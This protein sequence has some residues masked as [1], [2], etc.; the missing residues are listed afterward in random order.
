MEPLPLKDIHL[1]DA[2]SGWPPAPGWWLLALF[3]LIAAGFVALLIAR[4]Y[5]HL[6][7]RQPCQQALRHIARLRSQPVDDL[8]Q[9]LAELSALI[10]RAAI[11]CEPREQVASLRGEAWL[12]YLDRRLPD[13]P[14][15]QGPGRCLADA[16]YRPDNPDA[17]ELDRLFAL[18]E[19]WLKQHQI[20]PR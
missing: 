17:I 6:T 4:L 2:I 15:S 10:R 11:S 5:R 16:H 8:R 1:P 7:R 9:T 12:N 20:K 18:C 14:F 19:R 13:A 3:C